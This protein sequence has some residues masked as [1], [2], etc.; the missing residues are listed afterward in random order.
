MKKNSSVYRPSNR[1]DLSNP[2]SKIP[3]NELLQRANVQ[4]YNGNYKIKNLSNG[5]IIIQSHSTK[6][7]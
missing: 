3:H 7:K 2:H 1:E 4:I 6:K 5:K